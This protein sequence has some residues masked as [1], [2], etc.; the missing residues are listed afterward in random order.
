MLGEACRLMLVAVL[1]FAAALYMTGVIWV[2]Q[3]L[4]YPMMGRLGAAFEDCQSFHL[5][6]TGWI[7]GPPML[8]EG[9]TGVLLLWRFPRHPLLWTAFAL[10]VAI[11]WSTAYVQVPRHNRL[12]CGWDAETHTALVRT[13]W[14]R[15][16]AWTG[17]A[18]LLAAFFVRDF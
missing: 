9:I 4:H 6:K 14:V 16:W 8:V 2:V 15:T 3:I 12:K 1:H 11:W 18:A 5:S 10:L 13:N 17:R 7:V